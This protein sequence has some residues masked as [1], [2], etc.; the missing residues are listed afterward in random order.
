MA[1]PFHTQVDSAPSFWADG[2]V[3]TVVGSAD[4]T[5]GQFTMQ[6]QI[7][8]ENS[9][10][11]PHMHERY[12]EGFY[13]LDGEIRFQVGEDVITAGPSSFVWIPRGTPHAFRVMTKTSRALNF[14]TPGG[15]DEQTSMLF[16]KAPGRVMPDAGASAGVSGRPGDEGAMKAFVDRIRDL[17]SQTAVHVPNL[18][19]GASKAR[20][21]PRSAPPR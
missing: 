11:P 4:A 18:V 17:H 16:P 8:P 20:G 5:G 7:M 9:G 6:D 13:I 15:F 12:E 3:W 2:G 10:A 14:Y 1:K 19:A 21:E